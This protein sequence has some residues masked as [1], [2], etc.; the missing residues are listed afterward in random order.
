MAFLLEDIGVLSAQSGDAA[1]AFRMIGC[2][3]ALRE[4]IGTPRAPSLEAEIARELL[5]AAVHV[6]D[7]QQRALREQ[8]RSLGLA[9]AIDTALVIC[10]KVAQPYA[11]VE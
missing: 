1:S 7:D 10:G 4:A 8:G 6:P 2:A 11:A 5:A 3:D 9:Q